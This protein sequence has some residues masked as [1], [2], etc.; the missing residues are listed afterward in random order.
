MAPNM[1]QIVDIHE[2]AETLELVCIY[3]WLRMRFSIR[4]YA[5]N[6]KSDSLNKAYKIEMLHKFSNCYHSNHYYHPH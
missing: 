1:N 2:T 4:L 3:T 6:P 5:K